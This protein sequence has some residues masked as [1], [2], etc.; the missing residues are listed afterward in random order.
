[1]QIVKK[2]QQGSSCC[3]FWK[4]TLSWYVTKKFK[5]RIDLLEILWCFIFGF[6]GIISCSCNSKIVL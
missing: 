6:M 3:T 2:N 4:K 1:L 5:I